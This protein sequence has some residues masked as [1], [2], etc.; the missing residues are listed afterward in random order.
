[1]HI[2]RQIMF[3]LALV[4]YLPAALFKVVASSEQNELSIQPKAN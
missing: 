1:M 3:I 2:E 4:N